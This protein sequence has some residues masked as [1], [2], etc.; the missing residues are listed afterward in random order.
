MEKKE[1]KDMNFY[2]AAELADKLKMNHQV[3]TRKLQSGEIEGFKMGKDWRIEEEAI[4][5]WLSKISNSSRLTEKEKVLKNF[6]AKNGRLKQMPVMHKK[7]VYV[8]EFFLEKFKLNHTYDESEI[9]AI[10]EEYY[11]DYCTVRRE[12]IGEKMMYRNNG[13]YRRDTS[14][15]I[16]E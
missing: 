7:R 1:F 5:K 12:F 13:K 11:E 10:I 15:K 16:Q 6:F 8:L 4:R 14:Y 3:I 2:T 9:N